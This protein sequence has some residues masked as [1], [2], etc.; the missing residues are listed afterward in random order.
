MCV[1]A[2]A[3]AAAAA[4]VRVCRQYHIIRLHSVTLIKHAC[5]INPHTSSVR[6]LHLVYSHSTPHQHIRR[7][8]RRR[9]S[10]SVYRWYLCNSLRVSLYPPVNRFYALRIVLLSSLVCTYVVLWIRYIRL[11]PVSSQSH[12]AARNNLL[13]RLQFNII[14]AVCR[15]VGQV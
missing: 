11:S 7:R 2:V 8:R 14:N 12:G 13:K 4:A 1:H 5:S 9:P 10:H 6:G 15:S 3:A